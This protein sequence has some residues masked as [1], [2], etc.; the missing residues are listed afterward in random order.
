[1]GVPAAMR[2]MTGT[3]TGRPPSSSDVVRTRPR[4]PSMTLGVKPRERAEPRPWPTESG[5]LITSIAR[6]RLGKPPDEA[7]LFQGRNKPVNAGFG[8]QV[9][10]ILHFV[11]RRGHAGLGQP[12]VDE[13]QELELLAGQHLSLPVRPTPK[14]GPSQKQIM[15]GHYMFD[16]CSA[17]V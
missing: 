9:Q 10:G 8:P 7:A 4:S 16:M 6:A 1:M 15:N 17:T 13:T 3:A 5:S 14:Q 11:E 2:P 12:L